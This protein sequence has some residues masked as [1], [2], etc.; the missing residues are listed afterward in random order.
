MTPLGPSEVRASR[1]PFV[2]LGIALLR[3][4]AGFCL[5][6]PLQSL[7]SSSGVGLRAEGDRLLFEGGSYLLL[8][9]LRL[10]GPE[11]SAVARGLFPLFAVALLLGAASN[12]AL[13]VALNFG[14]RLRLGEWLARAL[15]RLPLLLVLSVGTGLGQ[16]V[17]FGL[18][19]ALAGAVPESMSRPIASTIGQAAV[20]LGCAALAGA[21]GG[22]SDVAK[23]CLVRHD[24]S[25]G[26]ALRQAG[27]CLKRR[28]LPA[29]FG[30]LPYALCFGAAVAL[31]ARLT[32]VL[33]VSRAGAWRVAAV[34]TLHQLIVLLAVALRSAWYARALRLSATAT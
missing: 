26:A 5:A 16:L 28:P 1:R 15:G 12:A 10:T 17:L 20:W 30:W 29:S 3:L 8:E 31:G 18:G 9:V 33:D 25:L 4:S 22:I 13:L 24:S 32:E 21:L 6:L 14:G 19:G 2:V 7:V 23:A 11:L 34:F 27:S